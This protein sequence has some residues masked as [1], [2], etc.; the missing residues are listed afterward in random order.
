MNHAEVLRL[1]TFVETTAVSDLSKNYPSTLL[2]GGKDGSGSGM[3][4]VGV[5]EGVLPC[6]PARQL[7]ALLQYVPTYIRDRGPFYAATT[8]SSFN[9]KNARHLTSR[10]LLISLPTSAIKS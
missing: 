2:C 4:G 9:V 7:G 10:F 3:D 5:I 1:S 6:V 8:K